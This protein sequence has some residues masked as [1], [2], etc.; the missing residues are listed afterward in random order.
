MI[1]PAKTKPNDLFDHLKHNP[2]Y[3]DLY[4]SYKLYGHVALEIM[5]PMASM[6]LETLKDWT[7]ETF[8]E[9]KKDEAEIERYCRDKGCKWLIASHPDAENMV[10]ARFIKRFGFPEPKIVQIATKEI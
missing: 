7:P 10:W 1:W 4:A 5:P 9:F 8:R 6:H 2:E 3:F